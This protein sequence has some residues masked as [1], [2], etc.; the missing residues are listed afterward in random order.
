MR[1][2]VLISELFFSAARLENELENE[3]E[4]GLEDTQCP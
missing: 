1:T 3:L 4:N 2:A